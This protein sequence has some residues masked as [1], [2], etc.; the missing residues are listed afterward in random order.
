[1]AEQSGGVMVPNRYRPSLVRAV[2]GNVVNVFSTIFFSMAS[3]FSVYVW[4][5]LGRRGFPGMWA[6]IWLALDGVRLRVEGLDKLDRT[7][8]YVFVSNHQS[9]IDIPILYTAL[10]FEI[11]FIAKKELFLIPFF[12]W[13][14]ASVGHIYI[15]RGNARK[16]HKSIMQAADSLRRKGLSLVIFPEGTRSP[17]GTVRTFKTGSFRLAIETGVDL[18]PVTIDG[19]CRVRPKGSLV[20]GPGD[21]VVRIGDPIPV[22]GYTKADKHELAERVRGVVVGMVGEGGESGI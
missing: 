16:A 7:K 18:V 5:R 21:V 9:A 6:R 19:S 1:M 20:P 11:A 3:M 8:R 15:D 22:Q 13:G 14:V 10:P 17:D 12:G 4:R 2:V